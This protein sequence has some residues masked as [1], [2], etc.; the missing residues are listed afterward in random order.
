MASDAVGEPLDVRARPSTDPAGA[1]DAFAQRCDASF[2]CSH[3]GTAAWQFESHWFHRL[4]RFELYLDTPAG[5]RKV[6]Q[7]AVGTGRR[8]RLFSDAVQLLPEHGDL[9]AAAMTAVLERLGPGT[10]VYGSPWSLEVPREGMLARIPGVAIED[11]AATS[12]DVIDLGRWASFEEYTR[13]VSTNV[14][15]NAKKAVNTYPGL[16]IVDGEGWRGIRRYVAAMALRRNL[17]QRKG[18]ERSTVLMALRSV[19]R[20]FS[21]GHHSRLAYLVDGDALLAYHLG[22]A[23]GRDWS[24]LE[25]AS[26]SDGAGVAWHLLMQM[27]ERAYLRSGG[28]G[29]FIMGS[30]DGTQQGQAAWEGLRRSR[31]QCCA[32]PFPTSVVRFRYGG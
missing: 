22:I 19:A 21:M 17:F 18:V 6:G 24:Y 23:F 29:R 32:T 16:A 2:R 27:V 5:E 31:Q 30:D 13:A 15:R 3:R 4:H 9:W 8:Y 12:L 26:R 20:L 1:W 11:V 10:Y 28:R 25:G 7:C 14:R